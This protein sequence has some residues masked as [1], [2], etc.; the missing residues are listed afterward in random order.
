MAIR[1]V[2]GLVALLALGACGTTGTKTKSKTKTKISAQ[3]D[4]L[5]PRNLNTGECGIFV[6]TAD[7][8]RRFVFFS[9]MD[10]ATASWWDN[11]GEIEIPQI[12]SNSQATLGQAP[13]QTYQLPNG[14]QLKLQLSDPEEVDNGT[15][16]RTGAIAQTAADGWEKVIPVS[17]IAACNV[18]PVG[19]PYSTRSIR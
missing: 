6:W 9:Q 5:A 1:Y 8:A 7:T 3:Q 17:G 2:I 4:R 10:S 13:D 19:A 15:R 16:Y 18:N 11:D 12:A 14:G